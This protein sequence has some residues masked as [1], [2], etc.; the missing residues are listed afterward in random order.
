MYETK[1][2]QLDIQELLVDA[3]IKEMTDEAEPL[4][5]DVGAR[6]LMRGDAPT[7]IVRGIGKKSQ[8]RFEQMQHRAAELWREEQGLTDEQIAAKLSQARMTM[9]ANTRALGKITEQEAMIAPFTE[10][11]RDS[12]RRVRELSD[13]IQRGGVPWVNRWTLRARKGL[14]G[15]ADVAALDYHLRVGATE[16]AKIT[17]SAT[18]GTKPRPGPR[19][20]DEAQGQ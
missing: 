14:A 10:T 2:R 9:A 15:D 13:K 5:I 11:A 12:L 16:V 6:R 1:Q 8:K 7:S 19:G 4:D 20:A 3:R 17:S 18:G